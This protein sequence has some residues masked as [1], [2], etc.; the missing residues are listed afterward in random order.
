ML[1]AGLSADGG[2]VGAFKPAGL[3]PRNTGDAGFSRRWHIIFPT[4]SRRWPTIIALI[5][6][7]RFRHVP[8]T[9]K[10]LFSLH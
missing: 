8:P 9:A 5:M 7:C 4:I 2:G 1:L 10:Q 6:I 3:A